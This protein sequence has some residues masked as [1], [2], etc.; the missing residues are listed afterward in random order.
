MASRPTPRIPTSGALT[1]G[2]NPVP[3][4]RPRLDTVK[5]PPLQVIRPQSPFPRRGRQFG[6][7]GRDLPHALL[8]DIP[9]DGNDQ[10]FLGID[11][12]SDV[13]VTLEDQS[14]G[15]G[16]ERSVQARKLAQVLGAR[17]DDEGHGRQL[18]AARPGFF[19]HR[20]AERL[21]FGHVRFVV[22]RH[23][24][25][26]QPTA[27]E[28]LSAPRLQPRQGHLLHRAEPGEVDL[29]HGG[30]RCRRCGT[31][32]PRL[33]EFLDVVLDDPTARSGTPHRAEIG[34]KFACQSPHRGA[35]IHATALGRHIRRENAGRRRRLR[36][37]RRPIGHGGGRDGCSGLARAFRAIFWR[38]VPPRAPRLRALGFA[39]LPVF[40]RRD[41][42]ND[43]A[44]VHHIAQRD[45]QIA[46][47]SRKRGWHFHGGLVGLD[48]DERIIHRD[49]IA[50]RYAQFDD[51][52]ILGFADIRDYDIGFVFRAH[53]ILGFGLSGSMPIFSMAAHTSAD[54]RT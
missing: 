29:G 35:R 10:P 32:H 12:E 52:H 16:V 36:R 30:Q 14:I 1:I 25:D 4:R 38:G 19:C 39:G 50:R 26:V 44:G 8:I 23:V 45:A 22:L 2:V 54:A 33:D 46:Q 28:V 43:V 6:D 31:G 51:L 5:H 47:C 37:A 34:A 9:D 42:R 15:A 20:L 27:V 40:V 3:P 48:H 21:Q 49:R 18:R 41:C 11:R 13:V 53:E 24:H 17:L 7:F